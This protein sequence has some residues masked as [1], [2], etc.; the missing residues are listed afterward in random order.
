MSIDVRTRAE[1]AVDDAPEFPAAERRAQVARC[2]AVR[3][4]RVR[5]AGGI[6]TRAAHRILGARDVAGHGGERVEVG[7]ARHRDREVAGRRRH[8][9]Q[10]LRA[11]VREERG[12]PARFRVRRERRAVQRDECGDGRH[13]IVVRPARIDVPPPPAPS[14]VAGH[15][16]ACR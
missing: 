14:Q 6:R 8:A 16:R 15:P 4:S 1:G 3:S 5:P 9:S 11:D 13:G 7:P 10:R 12:Q 2:R